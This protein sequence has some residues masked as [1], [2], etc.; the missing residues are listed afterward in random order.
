MC[1]CDEANCSQCDSK[2]AGNDRRSQ[3]MVVVVVVVVVVT[4]KVTKY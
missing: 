1:V 4:A 2:V 3:G